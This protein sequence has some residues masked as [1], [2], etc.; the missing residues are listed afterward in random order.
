MSEIASNIVS[1]IIPVWNR[2]E[3]LIEAVDSV[4]SQTY[5]PI[6]IIIVDDG[7][8][9]DTPEVA[10]AL[11]TKYP[12]EVIYKRQLNQGPGAARELGRQAAT[13]EFI[14]YLDSDDLLLPKK[15]EA[16]VT[17]L[18]SEPECA[19]SYGKTRYYRIG[20]TP[21]NAAH[22]RTGEKF[23][24]MFPAF[25]QSRWWSTSTPLFSRSICDRAGSWLVLRNE[26]DWE[27][28]CR[29]ASFGV[30]LHYCDQFVSD[31]R[32]HDNQRLCKNFVNS[33]DVMKDRAYAHEC[34]YQH[35]VRAG[36]NKDTSEM[37]HFARELFFLSRQCGSVGLSREAMKLFSL[38]RDASKD[39]G[40][41]AELII[42]R[43]LANV[44]GWSRMGVVSEKIDLL[45]SKIHSTST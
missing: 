2:A 41:K 27:Y 28:D 43:M 8:F 23:D 42:Y 26:E 31:T 33:P 36:V 40:K 22:K 7:S 12:N 44:F 45:R 20:E 38:A 34:I 10:K 24:K 11:A 6:E 9:D 19:V 21:K 18:R 30:R 35:A 37:Q 39:R 16:Q 15:F 3:L 17:G 14:Q 13:G 1:T 32:D 4:L 29:I 5:R 25:L